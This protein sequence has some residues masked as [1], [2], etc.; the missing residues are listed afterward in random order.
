MPAKKRAK[1]PRARLAKAMDARVPEGGDSGMGGAWTR[2][3]GTGWVPDLPD[4]RDFG[5]TC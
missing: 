4:M 3:V 1:D 5:S 2:T